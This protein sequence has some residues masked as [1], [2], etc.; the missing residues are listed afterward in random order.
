MA[1]DKVFQV[2]VDYGGQSPTKEALIV[3]E[4]SDAV[5]DLVSTKLAEEWGGA[6]KVAGHTLEVEEMTPDYIEATYLAS[7][8]LDSP[9]YGQVDWT[10]IPQRIIDILL[11]Q[12]DLD[13]EAAAANIKLMQNGKPPIAIEPAKKIITCA[14]DMV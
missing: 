12:C 9:F 10:A 5:K 8:E 4:S 2:V 3:A 11:P 7:V 6:D 1:D 14:A 13:L